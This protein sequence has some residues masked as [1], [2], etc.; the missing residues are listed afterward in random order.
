MAG[1]HAAR[2]GRFGLISDAIIAHPVRT[3]GVVTA[4]MVAALVVV[5]LGTSDLLAPPSHS[6]VPGSTAAPAIARSVPNVIGLTATR[7][8]DALRKQGLSMEC[9]TESGEPATTLTNGTVVRQFPSAGARVATGTPVVLT[10]AQP[11]TNGPS[12][13]QNAGGSTATGT[14]PAATGSGGASPAAGGSGPLGSSAAAPAAPAPAPASPPQSVPAPATAPA[15]P[16][17]PAVPPPAPVQPPA[18][19]VQPP[20]LPVSPPPPVHLP[21]PLPSLPLPT[22]SVTIPLGLGSGINH[23]L[24]LV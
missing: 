16:A 20:A 22:T 2:P 7:A 19:P 4:A 23:L 11:G 1:R 9:R 21:A 15:P 8:S 24:G 18:L 5:P 17:A 13:S 3:G 12:P 14:A 10:V 6:G